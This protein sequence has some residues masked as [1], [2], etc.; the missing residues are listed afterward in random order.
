MPLIY[1]ILVYSPRLNKY[2]M[3]VVELSHPSVSLL[4]FHDGNTPNCQ[5]ILA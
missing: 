4:G 5:S 3:K 1:I 2:L